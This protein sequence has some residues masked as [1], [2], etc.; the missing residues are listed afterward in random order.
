[1]VHVAVD[2]AFPGLRATFDA[3][4]VGHRPEPEPPPPPD[5]AK[6]RCDALRAEIVAMLRDV[7]R[8]R[9][10]QRVSY[11]WIFHAANALARPALGCLDFAL[12]EE[13]QPAAIEAVRDAAAHQWKLHRP[14]DSSDDIPV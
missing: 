6:E 11:E 9:T 8:W 13:T 1:M 5:P 10:G 7:G 14:A 2:R 3:E 12:D 4:L